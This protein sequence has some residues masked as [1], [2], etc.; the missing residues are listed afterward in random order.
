M[1]PIKIIPIKSK[2]ITVKDNLFNVLKESFSKI[3]LQEKDILVIASKVV[4]ITTKRII[5]FAGE[6][7]LREEFRTDLI[8]KEAEYVFPGS[9]PYLTIK[10]GIMCPNA[11]I[12]ES[13]GNG[14]FILWPKSPMKSAEILL[15]KLKKFYKLKELGIVIA[16][17][18][19]YPLKE[20][21]IG[22]GIGFAG[23]EGVKN[24]IGKKDI[25]LKPLKITKKSLVDTLASAAELAMGEGNEKI[26]FVLIRGQKI[27]F[28]N[29]KNKLNTID[30]SKCLYT[31]YF[32]K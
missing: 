20:G 18:A 29:K 7:K 3:K 13:N 21:T 9:Y 8:N 6:D 1:E 26:P 11:G 17:S 27:K 22:I 30:K 4:S 23:F 19:C 16:D 2:I 12:D 32:L 31:K 5:P 25:Y 15:K 10:N 14:S 24:Y 28:T